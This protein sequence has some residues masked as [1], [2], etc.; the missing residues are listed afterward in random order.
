MLTEGLGLM[1]A[2]MGMVFSFLTLLVL[3]MMASARIFKH[4]P[5]PADSPPP[6]GISVKKEGR[7]SK[8]NLAEVAIAIAVA[9]ARR[10]RRE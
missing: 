10:E 1:A 7:G 4:F 9:R 6:G 5:G 8:K 2:G 3:V